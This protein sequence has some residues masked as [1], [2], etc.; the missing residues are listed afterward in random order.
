MICGFL[1]GIIL[2]VSGATFLSLSSCSE[3]VNVV[4]GNAP[5][6]EFNIS[7]LKIKNYVNRLY[8]D[9]IA[10]EPLNAELVEGVDSL[11]AAGL[12]RES[13]LAIIRKL[14]TDTT[15]RP[16]E[17][18][19]KAAFVQNLYTLAK[20]RNLEG[21]GD[22]ALRQQIGIARNGMVKDSIEEN[23][24]GYFEK[25]AVIR[26]NQ[27]VLDSKGRLL[28]G[29]I[30]YHEMYA[31]MVDNSIYDQI[32]MNAFNFIRAVFD[33]L[34]WRLPTDGEFDRSFDMIEFNESRELFGR[35]GSHKND[36]ID[37]VIRSEGM[38]EGMIIWAYQTLLNRPPTAGEVVT[39]LPKYIESKNINVIFEEILV[40]DEYANFL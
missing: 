8:I 35:V 17:F 22:G 14:M 5:I 33:E 18:S 20:V 32:N 25:Q 36:F 30:R 15:F 38:F 31:Y 29:E 16:N 4:D 37:I 2:L 24:D 1:R 23:W 28:R 34:L 10:R 40:T 27:A 9:L 39:L 21:I 13:R 19:Y 11:K 7:D 12:S 6:S 3:E 26:R